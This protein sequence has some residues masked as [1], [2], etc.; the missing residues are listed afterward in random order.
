M[1]GSQLDGM[2]VGLGGGVGGGWGKGK[3]N[4]NFVGSSMGFLGNTLV[5]IA[6]KG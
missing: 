2:V 5:C 4:Y 6:S 3:G 1:L